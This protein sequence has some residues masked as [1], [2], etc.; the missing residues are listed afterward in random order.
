M[1]CSAEPCQRRTHFLGT[2]KLLVV[3][4]QREY[5]LLVLYECCV[6]LNFSESV[7]YFQ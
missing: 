4:L 7:D 3:V 5:S 1:L 6:Q 2:I